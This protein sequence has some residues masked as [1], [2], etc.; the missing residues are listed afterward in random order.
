VIL[1]GIFLEGATIIDGTG[2]PPITGL[3]VGIEGRKISFIG[4]PNSLYLTHDEENKFINVA[5]KTLLPG[6]INMHDHLVFKYAFGSFAEHIR[7]DPITLTLFAIKTSL[8]TL[9]SGMTTI[10]DMATH[11]GIAL[12]LRE[13]INRGDMLGPRIIACNQPICATGGHASEVCVEADG[14]DNVRH[15]ARTQL[16]LGADFIKVMASHDPYPMP[17]DEQT[18]AELTLEEIRAAYEE[19]H[20]W[21]KKAA[22]HVMGK[23][24]LRNVIEAGA[25]IIDHGTYL[26]DK[27]AQLMAEKK[28][29]YSPTLSGYCRQ[30]MDPKF[31]RGEKWAADH[32]PLVDPIRRS[33]EIAIRAGVKVVCSTDSTGRYAEEVELLRNAGMSPMDSILSCT[34]VAAEALGMKN[35]LGTVEVGKIA[36][37]VV[38]EGDPLGDP[39][40]LEGIVMVI[41]EGRLLHPQEIVF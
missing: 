11:H 6:L 35:Q 19:A 7:K 38:I 2:R 39:Y 22:C 17:W 36:D 3:V 16:K 18:R 5:G 29:F 10:R 33:A 8:Q 28:I 31:G 37:L 40:A 30:T 25:D 14:A 34:S 23:V 24:A 32:K 26:D 41:K 4:P 21:G 15:A 1:L 13:A 12:A 9:R 20:K 27:L